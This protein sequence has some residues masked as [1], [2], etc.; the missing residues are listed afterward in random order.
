MKMSYYQA[1]R[2]AFKELEDSLKEV[3]PMAVNPQI[4]LY[5]LTLKYEIGEKCILKRLSLMK[6]TG[7]VQILDDGGVVWVPKRSSIVK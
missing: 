2:N 1:R 3:H 6:K 7:M 5:D 4:L